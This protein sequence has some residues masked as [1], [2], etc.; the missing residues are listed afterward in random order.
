MVSSATKLVVPPAV[1]VSAPVKLSV[2]VCA[3]W[4]ETSKPGRAGIHPFLELA[5][6]EADIVT[7]LC[8]AEARGTASAAPGPTSGTDAPTRGDQRKA[9]TTRGTAI[10]AT[11]AHTV[12]PATIPQAT[13]P[14]GVH[15]KNWLTAGVSTTANSAAAEVTTVPTTRG[16]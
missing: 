1:S 14:N 15:P 5:R 12:A 13:G 11:V 6:R 7:A 8:E 16:L 4:N 9:A 3:A 10:P 2:T